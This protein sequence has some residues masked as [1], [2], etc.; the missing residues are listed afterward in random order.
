MRGSQDHYEECKQLVANAETDE[1]DAPLDMDASMDVDA[2]G[3]Q[4]HRDERE[5]TVQRDFATIPEPSCV[6]SPTFLWGDRPVD[7][8]LSLL[9][10]VYAEVVHWR[11][12]VFTVPLGA[13]GKRFV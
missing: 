7:E 8:I 5:Q 1:H 6:S 13:S 3:S 11:G 9:E 2:E 4:E 10:A 12:N